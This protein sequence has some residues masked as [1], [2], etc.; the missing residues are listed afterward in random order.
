MR[1][2]VL[3]KILRSIVGS[4]K[5]RDSINKL[6]NASVNFFK[7]EWQTTEDEGSPDQ[8]Y[9]NLSFFSAILIAVT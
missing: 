7:D 2:I 8:L 5:K 1:H 3:S 9:V 6:Q 4:V